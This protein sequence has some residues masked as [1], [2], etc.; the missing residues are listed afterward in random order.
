MDEV[1]I[2]QQKLIRKTKWGRLTLAS[3]A[4]T[5]PRNRKPLLSLTGERG[6]LHLIAVISQMPLG[7]NRK[8]SKSAV[9]LAKQFREVLRVP[10]IEIY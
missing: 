9:C 6:F 10:C 8:M 3:S 5:V 1:K 4:N 7:V 2:K